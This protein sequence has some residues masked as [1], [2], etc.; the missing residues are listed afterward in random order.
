M[1]TLM[2]PRY[3]LYHMYRLPS[4]LFL[5]CVVHTWSAAGTDF[6]AGLDLEPLVDGEAA[7]DD[8]WEAGLHDSMMDSLTE[9]DH[10]EADP[11][12]GTGDDASD[13]M[14]PIAHPLVD[15]VPVTDD[16]TYPP[17]GTLGRSRA[18]TRKRGRSAIPP[19]TTIGPPEP[20][21]LPRSSKRDGLRIHEKIVVLEEMLQ[22]RVMDRPSDCLSR[23]QARLPDVD[24]TVISSFRTHVLSETRRPEVLHTFLLSRCGK[25]DLESLIDDAPNATGSS[26]WLGPRRSMRTVVTEWMRFCIEPLRNRTGDRP[27]HDICRV[28]RVRQEAALVRL[29]GEQLRKFLEARLEVLRSAMEGSGIIG[30]TLRDSMGLEKDEKVIALEILAVNPNL[31]PNAFVKLMTDRGVVSD[32]TSMLTYRRRQLELAR[33]SLWLHQFLMGRA[34]MMPGSMNEVYDLARKEAARRHMDLAHMSI[35]VIDVW[36]RF[37]IVPL[38][39]GSVEPRTE[40]CYLGSGSRMDV[41]I[42]SPGQKKLMLAES[43]SLARRQRGAAIGI[44]GVAV[45]QTADVPAVVT[46]DRLGVRAVVTAIFAEDPDLSGVPLVERVRARVPTAKASEIKRIRSGLKGLLQVPAFMH[47]FLLKNRQLF[48]ERMKEL[49]SSAEMLYRSHDRN[50]PR[51]ISRQIKDW[52]IFCIQPLVACYSPPPC[53][54]FKGGMSR[55]EPFMHLSLEQSKA[56]LHT[57]VLSRTTGED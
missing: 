5:L 28:D 11:S 30:N 38:L 13:T 20:T 23:I 39:A 9:G 36:Y 55:A 41:M 49:V 53:F 37:C 34:G 50:P 48:P 57:I 18:T 17:Q 24:R 15:A 6:W 27:I 42:M 51:E 19:T 47:E 21:D 12:L 25:V 31:P 4:V 29:S 40:P 33:I 45:N 54:P 1:P 2:S 22:K 52:S 46:P 10:S 35:R 56:L 32:R 26:S 43:L 8:D 7:C 14:P 44:T 3:A 16:L